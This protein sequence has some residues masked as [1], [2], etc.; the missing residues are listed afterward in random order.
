MEIEIRAKLDNKEETIKKLRELG[1]I[2]EDEIDQ[3]DTYYVHKTIEK[4]LRGAGDPI[5]RIRKS[6]KGHFLTV[7]VL[8]EEKGVWVEHETEVINLEETKNIL[9]KTGFVKTFIIEKKRIKGKIDDMEV[10]ID[11]LNKIGP[12]VECEIISD[13]KDSAFERLSDFLKS[14]GISEENFERRGYGRIF[15]EMEGIKFDD[16][17]N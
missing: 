5:M 16:S 6:P 1:W 4:E 12:Y 13:D 15:A 17:I 10:C 11:D 7:K 3:E 8:T 2:G 9:V 14:I